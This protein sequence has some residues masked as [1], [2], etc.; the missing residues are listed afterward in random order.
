MSDFIITD[1]IQLETK[2]LC[3]TMKNKEKIIKLKYN[4]VKH[5]GK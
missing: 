5:L 4:K 2:C 3:M 1:I